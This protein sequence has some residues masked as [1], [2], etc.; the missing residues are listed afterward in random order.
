L[1]RIQ[2]VVSLAAGLLLLFLG[3]GCASGKRQQSTAPRPATLGPGST[4]APAQP[5]PTEEV[6]YFRGM[7]KR[8]RIHWIEGLTLVQGLLSAEFTGQWDPTEIVVIRQGRTYRVNANRLL[9]GLE[10][11][12][13]E[14]GDIV[15]IRR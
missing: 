5:L 12:L 11:P 1:R 7:F 13:L 14:P 3:A 9:R 2:W 4:V 8:Q 10:D 15:E 6:V